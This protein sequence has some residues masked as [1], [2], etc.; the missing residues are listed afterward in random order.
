MTDNSKNTDTR[1]RNHMNN[2]AMSTRAHVDACM[3]E[4]REG[5]DRCERRDRCDENDGRHGDERNRHGDSKT[6]VTRQ[7]I[8]KPFKSSRSNHSP[9]IPFLL[10]DLSCFFYSV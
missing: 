9:K 7:Q 1:N 5:S 2:D 8:G 3:K 10:I 4:G 6:C